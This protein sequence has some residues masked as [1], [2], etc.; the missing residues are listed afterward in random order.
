ML[1]FYCSNHCSIVIHGTAIYFDSMVNCLQLIYF[2]SFPSINTFHSNICVMLPWSNDIL[3]TQTLNYSFVICKSKATEDK[4]RKDLHVIGCQPINISRAI[5][6]M[7]LAKRYAW[8]L[9]LSRFALVHYNDVIMSMMASQITSLTIVYSTVYSG[10]D[11]RKHKS[12]ASLAFM[13]G[14]HWWPVNSPH[15]GPVTWKMFPFDD[16]IMLQQMTFTHTLPR[17]FN[18]MLVK[19]PWRI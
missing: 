15:K 2:I 18:G 6:C 19:W 9:A 4:Y 5:R 14:I 3:H 8:V 12:S 16:V 7:S 11:Q 17:T 10:A 13:R 1:R